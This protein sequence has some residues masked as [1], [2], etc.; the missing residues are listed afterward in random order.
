MK[1]LKFR[2]SPLGIKIVYACFFA[3]FVIFA[4]AYIYPMFWAIINSLKTDR[5]FAANSLNL[6]EQWRFQNYVSV[7]K[8]FKVAGTDIRGK[9]MYLYFDM[10]FNS[11][12]IL[13]VHVFVNVTS[14]AML[15]YAIARFR[16]PGKNFL[17]AVI[18]FA[19]T[20]PIIGS[21]PAKYKMAV[22]LNMV[23]N[24]ATIWLMW[25]AGFDFAFI[26]FYGYFKGIS[27]SYSESAKI[28]GANNWTVLIKVILPQIIP[29]IVAVAITQ[30]ISIW[31]N[32]SIS[33]IYLPIYPNLAYGMYIFKD[34]YFLVKDPM[35]I[36]FATAVISSIP[37]IVL[38]ACSQ[39]LILTNM[40]T[41]GLKG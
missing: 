12:W 39:N 8:D 25:A 9:D 24:P 13:V 1:E 26:V 17:Y 41:G 2:K 15:A 34:Y 6:P 36:Y 14:S 27:A 20:I 30:A 3:M 29:C 32:Y 4:F 40:T 21:G 10:L 28:D 23:N 22:A 33:M 19:N 16:F 31:N 7:F 35:P 5:E 37:I 11:L 38:Y 18:I